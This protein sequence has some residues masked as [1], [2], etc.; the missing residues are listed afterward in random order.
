MKCT[1]T[2]NQFLNAQIKLKKLSSY[3]V[4]Q[5]LLA[6]RTMLNKYLGDENYKSNIIS[7]TILCLLSRDSKPNS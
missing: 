6:V 1:K 7:I 2:A 3:L 4:I 5:T